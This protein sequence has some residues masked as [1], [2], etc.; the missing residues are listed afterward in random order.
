MREIKLRHTFKRKRDGH[1]YQII[2]TVT[3]DGLDM[4]SRMLNNE[5]W[6]EVGRDEYTGLKDKN[7]TEIYEGDIL[8]IH[9][10]NVWIGFDP[11]GANIYEDGFYRGVVHYTPSNGF[12]LTRVT[13]HSDDTGKVMQ[14][15][16]LSKIVQ[17][18]AVVIGDIHRTPQLL[19]TP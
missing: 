17:S 1:I 5:L 14:R 12:G 8:D 9:S 7:G 13:A 4:L 15:R 3:P 18:A 6:D 2:W 11:S 10:E 19:E 16:P